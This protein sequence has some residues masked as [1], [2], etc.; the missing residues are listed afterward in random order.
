MHKAVQEEDMRRRFLTVLVSMLLA[1]S[2]GAQGGLTIDAGTVIVE[3]PSAPGPVKKAVEDLAC[4]MQKMFGK[5]PAVVSQSSGSAIEIAAPAGGMPESFSIATRGN[6]IILTGA[7]MR[8]V[9]FTIYTFSQDWLEVDPMYYRN[10]HVPA[11]KT[12]IYI[13]AESIGRINCSNS[14]E[15]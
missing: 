12:S 7:D 15:S 13:P 6:H 5:R 8:G 9:I 14:R 10:D 3:N 11:K 1:G 2:A 4:D